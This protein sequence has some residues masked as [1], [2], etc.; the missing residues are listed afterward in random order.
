[1][2]KLIHWGKW[3][4]DRAYPIYGEAIWSLLCLW[5]RNMRYMMIR[6]RTPPQVLHS[7]RIDGTLNRNTR[8]R[9]GRIEWETMGR[10]NN[11]L[12]VWFFISSR[13]DK[14]CF[15]TNH[16]NHFVDDVDDLPEKEVDRVLRQKLNVNMSSDR[17]DFLSMLLN[18]SITKLVDFTVFITKLESK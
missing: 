12:L 3:A 2:C 15:L 8:R 9:K 18:H 11:L 6:I 4:I 7:M 17:R 16:D 14:S 13:L 1:M 10:V 5:F